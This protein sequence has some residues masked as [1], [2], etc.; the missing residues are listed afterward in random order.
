[1]NVLLDNQVGAS[2]EHPLVVPKAPL[3]M[4]LYQKRHRPEKRLSRKF[5]TAVEKGGS[6]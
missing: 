5:L 3:G 6:T 4:I 2:D 1:M